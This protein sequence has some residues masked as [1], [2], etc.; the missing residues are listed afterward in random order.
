MHPS[1]EKKEKK[2][3]LPEITGKEM[4]RKGSSDHPSSCI[5]IM[6]FTRQKVL[7]GHMYVGASVVTRLAACPRTVPELQAPTTG[8]TRQG[9]AGREGSHSPGGEVRHV[10]LSTCRQ[11]KQPMIRKWRD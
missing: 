6:D 1:K 10:K 5:A 11:P 9:S 4:N 2:R 3:L 8:R 7:K